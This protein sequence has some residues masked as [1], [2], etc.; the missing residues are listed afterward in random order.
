MG[1]HM[2]VDTP[3]AQGRA[4]YVPPTVVGYGHLTDLTQDNGLMG[5]L[6][7]ATGTMASLSSPASGGGAPSTQGGAPST[8]GGAPGQGVQGTSMSGNP[9]VPGAHAVTGPTPTAPA[10]GVSPSQVSHPAPAMGTG[11]TPS[12]GTLASR[13]T[14]TAGTAGGGSSGGGTLPFTGGDVGAVAAVGG[15]ATVLGTAL[16]RVTRRRPSES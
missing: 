7:F 11:A 4:A 12:S 1:R 10:T 6:H 5:G 2:N 14:G 16:R 15:L 9:S 8:Q 13:A 3:R